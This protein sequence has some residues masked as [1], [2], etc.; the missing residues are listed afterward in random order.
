VTAI[1]DPDPPAATAARACSSPR[2][3]HVVG[4]LQGGGAERWVAELVPR[5][6]A[7]GV[8]SEIATVYDPNLSAAELRELGVPVHHRAKRRGFD[9]LH[10]LWL[11]GTIARSAP[12]IVHTHQWAGKYI[13]G[14]AAV[15]ARTPVLVHTEHSPN[16]LLPG[17]GLLVQLLW[18]RT[19]A[20]VT[21]TRANADLI[22]AREPVRRFEIIRNGLPIPPLPT[23][24]ERA[25]ARRTLAV[26]ADTVVFAVVASLQARKNPGRALEALARMRDD[27]AQPVRLEYFGDGPLRGELAARAAALGVADRVR[28]RGFR[29][30]VRDLLRGV[31]VFLTVARHEIAPIS[32]VEGMAVGLPVIGTPHPGTLEMVEHEATGLVVDWDAGKLADG[33]RRARDDAAWRAACGARGRERVERDYDIEKVADQHVALDQRL[34]S[35]RASRYGA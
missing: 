17:E 16:P 12:T 31:D 19:D 26:S 13:G 28:F 9:P 27:R 29:S 21:F 8:P 7:R 6:Q 34:A 25:A 24:D 1:L 30:D 5:L 15:L 14:G 11:R 18:R 35:S 23:R 3:L 10:F 4:S 20:V 32:I 2:V 33:M 22:R